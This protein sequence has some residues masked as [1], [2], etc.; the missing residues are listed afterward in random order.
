[1]LMRSRPLHRPHSHGIVLV[2][3]LV[4]LLVMSI[5][6]TVAVRLA[7]NSSSIAVGLR[8][9]NEAQQAADLALRWCELQLRLTVAGDPAADTQNFKLLPKGQVPDG[10]WSNFETHRVNSLELPPAVLGAAG[11]QPAQP[12]RCMVQELDG[13]A[14]MPEDDKDKTGANSSTPE[15]RNYRIT[16]RGLSRDFNE[17]TP[18]ETRGSEVWLQSNLAISSK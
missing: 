2:V 9:A 11:I 12:P 13:W 7:L 4:L 15:Y 16:V 5:G 18:G 3:A 10:A 1:M 8:G 17:D 6:S 14:G